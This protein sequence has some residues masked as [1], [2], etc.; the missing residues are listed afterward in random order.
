MGKVLNMRQLAV[1]AMNSPGLGSGIV[2]GQTVGLEVIGSAPS[3]CPL[4]SKADMEARL[5][6][7]RFKRIMLGMATAWLTLAEQHLRN[8]QTVLVYETP[9]GMGKND[10]GCVGNVR[11][12]SKADIEEGGA[13]VRFTPKADIAESDRHVRFVPKADI[14]SASKFDFRQRCLGI[15]VP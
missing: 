11:F 15:G 14:G 8:S 1:S 4:G 13:D 3:Q 12:G 7:V 9:T 6:N 5:V 10:P 2:A